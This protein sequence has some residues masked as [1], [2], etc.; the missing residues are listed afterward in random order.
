MNN[1]NNYSSSSENGRTIDQ[2]Q[3]RHDDNETRQQIIMQKTVWVNADHVTAASVAW[4]RAIAYGSLF[5]LIIGNLVFAVLFLLDSTDRDVVNLW[6]TAI[7]WP[8]LIGFFMIAF[9]AS[10]YIYINRLPRYNNSERSMFF[11]PRYQWDVLG[12]ETALY[13]MY[14][15]ELIMVIIIIGGHL[16]LSFEPNNELAFDLNTDLYNFLHKFLFFCSLFSAFI[17]LDMSIVFIGRVYQV[18]HVSEI[19]AAIPSGAAAHLA[20]P[21]PHDVYHQ[22]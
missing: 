1:N 18:K 20:K 16:N 5:C 7:L 21:D 14:L 11:Y 19:E 9:T 10:S 4:P 8:L 6:I 15:I 17:S 12:G 3:P 22:H 13:L 2:Y